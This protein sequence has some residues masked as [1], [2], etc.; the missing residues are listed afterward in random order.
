MAD[1]T[2]V[3]CPEGA[4]TK[5]ITNKTT[6]QIHTL[7]TAGAD[8]SNLVYLSTYRATGGAVPTLI[9]E[10]I[11]IEGITAEVQSASGI[12]VYIWCMGAAGSVRVD[13]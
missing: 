4:W 3:A 9:T 6:G 10:G 7:F 8:G 13:V 11:P 5:V 1:P 2:T 12:D